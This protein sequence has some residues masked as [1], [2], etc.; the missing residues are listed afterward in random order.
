MNPITVAPAA[1][2]DMG[3]AVTIAAAWLR[4][5][6]RREQAREKSCQEYLRD[7]PS[8]SPVFDLGKHARAIGVDEQAAG[9]GK[10]RDAVR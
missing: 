1:S 10:D 3:A 5:Q 6:S 4:A 7:Q 2:D 8:D 9:A